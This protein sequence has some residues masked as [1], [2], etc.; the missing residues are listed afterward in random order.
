L[1]PLFVKEPKD[2][3]EPWQLLLL[4]VTFHSI[5]EVL[6]ELAILRIDF[7]CQELE[8]C[9]LFQGFEWLRP[10]LLLPDLLGLMDLVVP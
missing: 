3:E 7:P 4:R 2:T 8:E 5:L 9:R 10:R 1:S 6:M